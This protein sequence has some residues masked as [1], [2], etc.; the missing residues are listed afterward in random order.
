ME[1]IEFDQLWNY[2]QPQETEERFRELLPEVEHNPANKAELLTQ[3]AR[4]LGLQGKFTEAH[5]VLD[6]A[7]SLITAEMPRA[8]V[9]LALERGRVYN[10]G[11]DPQRAR[12]FF[13]IAM[14]LGQ[15]AGEDFYTIDA[16]HMLGIAV[17]GEEGIKWNLHGLE[18]AQQTSDERAQR[19]TATLHNNLGWD[20]FNGQQYEA[21]VAHFEQCRQ[22]HEQHQNQQQTL[23]ARWSMARTWRAM[24]RTAEAL[25]EQKA[26]A[27]ANRE[28]PDGFVFEEIGECLVA[29]N[30]PEEATQA[31][32]QA[33][34][35]LERNNWYLARRPE[36]L[37]ELRQLGQVT[38]IP[39]YVVTD[40]YPTEKGL[41]LLPGILLRDPRPEVKL[42]TP[43]HSLL[44][45]RLPDGAV[46][47]AVLVTFG[48]SVTKEGDNLILHGRVEDQLLHLTVPAEVGEI[49]AGTQVWLMDKKK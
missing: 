48:I 8:Q 39:L 1:W 45:L 19:W 5:Q 29:L 26:L 4:T 22:W 30:R 9:R 20:Y 33:Y 27:E 23:V 6:E 37:K 40:S 38:G 42:M 25:A 41:T 15:T 36:R 32:A 13:E 18:L 10:S 46:K 43:N 31:F 35:W 11:G 44:E 49:P 21:A 17:P 2:N 28:H 16:V 34:Y 24:G 7:K 47:E 3:I 12:A 14:E